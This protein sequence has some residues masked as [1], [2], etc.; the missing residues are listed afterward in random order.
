MS[1]KNLFKA[2]VSDEKYLF[3][4]KGE[5]GVKGGEDK[6]MVNLPSNFMACGQFDTL[7]HQFREA[8]KC[9]Q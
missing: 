9:V 5:E 2:R 6:E 3:C 4:V 1:W 7:R 8:F